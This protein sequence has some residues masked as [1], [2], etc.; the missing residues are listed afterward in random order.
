MRL[1]P[2][3]RT[4]EEIEAEKADALWQDVREARVVNARKQAGWTEISPAERLVPRG[5]SRYRWLV[6]SELDDVYTVS[7]GTWFEPRKATILANMAKATFIV[8]AAGDV[9]VLERVASIPSW[10][11]LVD[12]QTRQEIAAR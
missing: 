10:S 12:R 1:I 11:W 3:L 9:V 8:D 2:Q 4:V 5:P 6:D 7:P